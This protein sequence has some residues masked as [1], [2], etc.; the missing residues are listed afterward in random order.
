M[1]SFEQINE[2]RY[3]STRPAE[4]KAMTLMELRL[5]QRFEGEELE[6]LWEMRPHTQGE[7]SRWIDRLNGRPALPISDEQLA[8]VQ[9]S[10][11]H[12]GI[13]FTNRE[14][15]DS[16][17]QAIRPSRPFDSD[18][19]K[20]DREQAF[21]FLT[22]YIPP[23]KGGDTFF[24]DLLAGQVDEALSPEGVTEAAAAV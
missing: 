22:Q 20:W 23:R 19:R 1:N 2:A 7:V 16:F 12:H 17:P 3:A 6:R 10:A 18:P 13:D 21:A 9:A 11:V 15:F 24:E 5:Q 14:V 4:T 8:E